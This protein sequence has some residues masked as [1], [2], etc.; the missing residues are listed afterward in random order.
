MAEGSRLWLMGDRR[1]VSMFC[2]RP[3]HVFIR[4]LLNDR[5]LEV[6][7]ENWHATLGH[8]DLGLIP[9]PLPPCG[10]VPESSDFSLPKETW[11]ALGM[12][13]SK[14]E[15]LTLRPK[16][17]PPCPSIIV[18]D[19]SSSQATRA[20]NESSLTPPL[21]PPPVQSLHTFIS[22][23]DRTNPHVAPRLTRSTAAT[24]LS[25]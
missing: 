15:S 16:P 24:G 7:Q 1:L 14:P 25:H 6:A 19:S 9:P 20:K 4:L 22:S 12:D 3:T 17:A 8:L 13:V 5:T 10:R 23:T 11:K 21:R 18:G 2:V